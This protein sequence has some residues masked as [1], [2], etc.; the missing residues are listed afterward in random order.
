[1]DHLT[2]IMD[3]LKYAGLDEEILMIVGG[4]VLIFALI[5]VVM[6]LIVYIFQAVGLYS[7]AKRRGIAHAWL[8]WIPMLD[9][10]IVG[11]LADQYQQKVKSKNSC[12]RLI[13]L[14]LAIASWVM[15][16]VIGGIC[17]G[18]I[19]ESLGS[20]VDGDLGSLIFALTTAG[21]GSG[22]L[23]LLQSGLNL[24]RM[25]F[26]HIS[27]YHIYCAANPRYS[28]TFL[29]LGI[30]FPVTIPFFLFFNRKKD[31][32]MRIPEPR[33]YIPPADTGD[34]L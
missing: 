33:G 3:Q 19:S 6:S 13:L 11:S 4:I 29:V 24:A 25:V 7:A 16:W 26:W 22:A 14:L 15:G 8:A 12:N 2:E 10:W 1:M 32:G 20:V 5:G 17:L 18:G 9:Y 31:E 30:I 23:E 28:V 34:Y 27:L 21:A